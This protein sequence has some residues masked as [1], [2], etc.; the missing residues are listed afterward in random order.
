MV[1]RI[2]TQSAHDPLSFSCHICTCLLVEHGERNVV[3]NMPCMV[4]SVVTRHSC[5]CHPCHFAHTHHN[6]CV[7][8]REPWS[9]LSAQCTSRVSTLLSHHLF[10]T[11]NHGGCFIIKC[12]L[13]ST[14]S[15]CCGVG[16]G[17]VSS[18]SSSQGIIWPLLVGSLSNLLSP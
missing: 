10:P 5:D 6:L 1:S 13:L 9:G 17:C 3:C 8:C 12:V 2:C 4:V 18:L 7:V 15:T 11:T 16:V 14:L